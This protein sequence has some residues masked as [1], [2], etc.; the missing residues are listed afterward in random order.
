M[1]QLFIETVRAASEG[2]SRREGMGGGSEGR[3]R[4]KGMGGGSAEGEGRRERQRGKERVSTRKNECGEEGR[5]GSATII[6][7]TFFM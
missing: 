6:T 1:R 7:E 2:L 5:K 3:R 4:K